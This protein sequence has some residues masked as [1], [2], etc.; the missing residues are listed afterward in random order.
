MSYVFGRY[1]GRRR[2]LD[3]MQ[4]G[5][6]R[7]VRVRISGR[8]QGVGYRAWTLAK[9]EQLNLHGWVRNLED[10]RVEALL[11]GADKTVQTMMDLFWTGPAGCAVADVEVL[12]AMGIVPARFDVKPTVAV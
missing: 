5:Q 10:G 12:D 7:A 1:D 4:N 3:A 9:A 6:T 11:S 2:I 8:V